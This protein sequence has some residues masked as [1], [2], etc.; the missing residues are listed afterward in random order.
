[1]C[2]RLQHLALPLVVDVAL[3]VKSNNGTRAP[4]AGLVFLLG[5]DED[6]KLLADLNR[7]PVYLG[8]LPRIPRRIRSS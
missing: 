7:V 6:L 1:M 2:R 4:P 5:L 3:V 8:S